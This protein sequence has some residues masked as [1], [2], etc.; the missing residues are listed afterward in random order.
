MKFSS[1]VAVLAVVALAGKTEKEKAQKQKDRKSRLLRNLRKEAPARLNSDLDDA[2]EFD[3]DSIGI[4]CLTSSSPEYKNRGNISYAKARILI[5]Q[6][7]LTS[8]AKRDNYLQLNFGVGL[9]DDD[10]IN[11]EDPEARGLNDQWSVIEGPNAK[12]TVKAMKEICEAIIPE[13]YPIE[14]KTGTRC[15]TPKGSKM[16]MSASECRQHYKVH[17]LKYSKKSCRKAIK[18]KAG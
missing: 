1:T 9:L 11:Y 16:G 12:N 17:D 6:T 18:N 14:L 13:N 3:T 15:K 8:F 5:C 2:V 4:Q 7:W 10:E